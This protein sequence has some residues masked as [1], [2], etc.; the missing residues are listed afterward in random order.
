MGGNL[1][2]LDEYLFIQRDAD[3]LSGVSIG[4]RR[5]DVKRFHGLRWRTCWTARDDAVTDFQ[6]ACSD[7]AGDDSAER[8]FVHV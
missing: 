5:F 8:Q 2:P 4:R 6:S 3:G 1:A 7:S